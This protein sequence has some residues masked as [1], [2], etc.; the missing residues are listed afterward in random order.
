ME[1]LTDP[2]TWWIEPFTENPFMQ[3]ALAAGLLA[4]VCTAVVGTWVV[5]RGMSFLGDALAHGACTES[6]EDLVVGD[7]LSFLQCHNVSLGDPPG[8]H[9]SNPGET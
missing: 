9:A 5:L 8:R 7:S 1:F 4:V 3:R 2:W 6:P